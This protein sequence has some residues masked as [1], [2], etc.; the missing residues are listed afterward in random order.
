ML[1][2]AIANA[3]SRAALTRLADEQAALRR[4]AVRVAEGAPPAAVFEAVTVETL[5]LLGA[6]SASFVRYEPDGTATIL[7]ERNTVAHPVPAGTRLTI[8]GDSITARILRTQRSCRISDVTEMNSAIATLAHER[9]LR[10]AVAA[11]IMVDGRLWGVIA[12]HWLRP[13]PPPAEAETQID[14]F[15]QLVATAIAN[16]NSRDQLTAS[17]A[18]VLTTADEA[19]RRVVRDLH[20]GAQQ[21]LLQTI[22]TLKLAQR[23]LEPGNPKPESL[24]AEA[25]M[26]AQRGNAELRELAHGLL[27][28]VLT[29]GGLR[30]GISSIVSRLDLLVEV[31]VINDRFAPEIEASAYFVVAEALTN[32]VKHSNAERAE[33]RAF[34][35][36]GSLHVEV[37]DD[38]DGGADPRGSGLVGLSDRV[39]A[40]DG[41]LTVQSPVRGGTILAATLPLRVG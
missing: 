8:E 10:S 32:V 22:V 5:T 26:H 18:R 15:A 20:D 33:V 36:D 28:A 1:A 2:T 27:P 39:T 38:G 23:A 9:G 21:R 34:E 12:T 3:D 35:Q 14:N 29:Q 24:I 19:R 7:A 25:L 6:D 40:L 31:D 16:A 41:Q 11:P 17:R 13:D 37:R 4:V 30:S